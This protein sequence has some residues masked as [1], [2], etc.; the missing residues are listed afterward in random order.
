MRGEVLGKAGG[1]ARFSAARWVI[2][3]HGVALLALVAHFLVYLRYAVEAVRFPFELDYGEG[4]V[5]QQALC[6]PDGPM[7][8]DITRF[9][10]L[11]F[12]YPP[13]YHLVARAAALLNGD[14]LLAGR[15]VSVLCTLL[16]GLLAAA[17][18][19]ETAGPRVSR[20]ARLMG[21]AAGGLTVFCYWPVVA[22]SP[23]MRVDMLAV[24]LSFL[25]V[26]LA[27]RAARHPWM[28]PAAVLAFVLAVYTKQTSVSAPL[29]VLAVFW[30][31]DR[32]MALKAYGLGLVAGLAVLA[33]LSW[34]TEGGFLRHLLL[35]NLN[36]FSFGAAFQVVGR[37][38][39]QLVFLLLALYGV[40]AG[41]RWAKNAPGWKHLPRFPEYL[42]RE[43]AAR[44]MA[45]LTLYLV[46][47]T[48]MLLTLGKSGAEL[49]Y[50]IE[51]MCL[52]SVLIGVLLIA[53]LD[54]FCTENAPGGRMLFALLVPAALLAQVAIM[55][56]ARGY[57]DS[58]GGADTM[59]QLETLTA[60]I[61]D[62][63]APVLSDDMVL[64]LKA[65]KT[66]PWEPAIFAELASTGRWDERLIV[67]KIMARGF[68]FILTLAKPG[69]GA[70]ENR[71]TPAVH[72]AIEAAYPRLEK[73]GG[74][75]LHLPPD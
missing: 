29:A 34:M 12:H 43:A 73:L 6:I 70:Y 40:A 48:L 55:P 19:Y 64:L 9:P 35:Y 28:L 33:V 47:A 3:A 62:A 67:D 32:R 60:R 74:H 20:T 36:R 27:L 53:I 21:A 49:N 71:F 14:M 4:I 2:A 72:Q 69:E 45:V 39:Q 42:R 57:G 30:I 50:L 44:P 65:G 15:A 8:G 41:W 37:H 46:L 17:L 13:V 51:W 1:I 26:W 54:P 11:V 5:W 56:A 66:V 18:A 23:L 68:A 16:T 58:G 31:T 59:R 25:G 38:V 63:R 52:W 7:Y 24:L 22:W 10:F 61:R 75:T